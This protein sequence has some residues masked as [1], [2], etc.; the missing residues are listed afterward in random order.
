MK[1]VVVSRLMNIPEDQYSVNAAATECARTSAARLAPI[2]FHAEPPTSCM[3][4]AMKPASFCLMR[5]AS[6]AIQIGRDAHF[7]SSA[8]SAQSPLTF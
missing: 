1:F 5:S 3:C 6:T 8:K 2:V 4:N 7:G